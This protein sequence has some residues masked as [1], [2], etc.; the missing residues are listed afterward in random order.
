MSRITWCSPRYGVRPWPVARPGPQS[1][2]PGAVRRRERDN[3]RCRSGSRLRPGRASRPGPSPPVLRY[4]EAQISS[5]TEVSCR[6]R[7]YMARG[8]GTTFGI[9]LVTIALP[10]APAGRG[11][12]PDPALALA[13][14]SAASGLP[15][16]SHWLSAR[17]QVRAP[18]QPEQ[19][20]AMPSAD[21]G[22]GRSAAAGREV[23]AR[24]VAAREVAAREVAARASA[25]QDQPELADVIAALRR[26][27]RRAGPG[28]RPRRRAAWRPIG[29][30]AGTAVRPGRPPGR[31]AWSAGPAV[32]AGAQLGSAA[33]GAALPALAE[34]TAAA[35]ALAD[36]PLG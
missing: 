15:R 13:V 26:A 33:L 22:A 30:S 36:S 35:G 1:I 29:G 23:A 11:G 14:L 27:M 3:R 6:K 31:A 5:V 34:L 16:S 8:I 18:S 21:P 20:P 10:A 12:R 25:N 2:H 9:A 32:A 24:E 4:P 17:C 7:R 28:R 19:S